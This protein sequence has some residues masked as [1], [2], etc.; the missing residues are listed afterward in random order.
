MLS[1]LGVFLARQE[2]R[3]VYDCYDKNRDGNITYSEFVDVLKSSMSEARTDMVKR[4]WAKVAGASSSVSFDALCM[5]YNAPAHPR[6]QSRAKKATTV[7]NDFVTLLGSF[8]VDGNISQESFV[9]YYT[10]INAVMPNAKENYFV[11]MIT[12]TWGLDA[13]K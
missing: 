10:N 3:T 2:L 6:V 7:M 12:K 4:A 5:A 13:D 8:A 11:D 9:A 1:K